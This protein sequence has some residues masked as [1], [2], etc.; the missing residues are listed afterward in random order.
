M[1]ITLSQNI[2]TFRKQRRLTQEQLAEGI[3]NDS[4]GFI[5][6]FVNIPFSTA[7]MRII[8]RDKLSKV[9]SI[10]SIFSQGLIP[11]ASAIAGT[12]LQYMGSAP[13]L[14]ICAGGFLATALFLL[15]N[16]QTAQI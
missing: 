14:F 9:N 4:I 2:R 13:L 11:I 8:D 1:E 6:P 7:L 12:V 15:L 10:L 5:L 3:F 16:K